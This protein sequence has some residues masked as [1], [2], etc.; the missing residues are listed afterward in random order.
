MI[1]PKYRLLGLEVPEVAEY[2]YPNS[3]CIFV[4]FGLPGFLIMMFVS[5]TPLDAIGTEVVLVLLTK[6]V[7]SIW[8]GNFFGVAILSI[9]T[10]LSLA[11]I[12]MDAIIEHKYET[13]IEEFVRLAIAI[14]LFSTVGSA[15]IF[16]M[17][18]INFGYAYQAAQN[19]STA[20]GG[21]LN[22]IAKVANKLTGSNNFGYTYND[23]NPTSASIQANGI[24][25]M[26]EIY[27]IPSDLA[28][29]ISSIMLNPQKTTTIDVASLALNPRDII[30]TSWAS[31]DKA[32]SKPGVFFK[33]F[34]KCYDHHEYETLNNLQGKPMSCS[35][36]NQ[37]WASS[38]Q[39][40]VNQIEQKGHVNK[41]ALSDMKYFIE[42]IKDGT[43][44]D[45]KSMK[46]AYLGSELKVISTAAK[47]TEKIHKSGATTG[48]TNPNNGLAQDIINNLQA[49]VGFVLGA[50]GTV[51]MNI[52]SPKDFLENMMMLIQE[53]AIAIMFILLPLVVVVGL[54]PIFGNNY[55]LIL[56]YAFS[57]FLIKLWIPVYWLIYVA[58]LNVSAVLVSFSSPIN[59]GIH[60]IDNGIQYAI[61]TFTG[62]TAFAQTV[63]KSST[64]GINPVPSSSKQVKS[65]MY[66]MEVANEAEKWSAFNSALLSFFA[67]AIPGVFGSAATYLIGRGTMEAGLA[68]MY[69]GLKFMQ[70][71]GGL[72]SKGLAA[73]LSKYGGSIGGAAG[74]GVRTAIDTKMGY[75]VMRDYWKDRQYTR[76]LHR[77]ALGGIAR[78]F[79]IKM[80]RSTP[81][82]IREAF[83]K[84][85]VKI[86]DKGDGVI[87]FYRFDKFLGIRDKDGSYHGAKFLSE[88]YRNKYSQI[89]KDKPYALINTRTRDFVQAKGL[90]P[91]NNDNRIGVVKNIELLKNLNKMM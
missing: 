20:V 7:D 91:I 19:G 65:I 6:M 11:K 50:I 3:S 37:M 2:K 1:L 46:D 81:E 48:G 76:E 70:K 88:E 86:Q 32:S 80:R 31:M 66:A 60:Y 47:E 72:A 55:K 27:A 77:S 87:A 57:F 16:S 78:D 51:G 29:Q 54:L 30:Y 62:N 28:Y 9:V 33:T 39:N 35:E 14:L 44:Q 12:A 15:T 21:L 89:E 75:T 42:L 5:Y 40:I 53:Y 84:A 83:H 23:S 74:S 34:A 26:A 82:E 90:T 61:T 85:D 73:G 56:K 13:A 69:E 63:I 10:F 59:D 58:M 4:Q 18:I 8:S 43:L 67:V 68:S 38:A 17:N 22:V 41:A 36:F 79:G 24:P 25:L 64:P 52:A 45:N 71:M 49:G